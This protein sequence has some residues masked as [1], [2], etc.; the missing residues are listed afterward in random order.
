[1]YKKVDNE[2]TTVPSSETTQTTVHVCNALLFSGMHYEVQKNGM[3]FENSMWSEIVDTINQTAIFV[4]KRRRQQ[5]KCLTIAS[6]LGVEYSTVFA[7]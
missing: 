1:M 7:T 3:F 2:Q 6:Q 4:L 5:P